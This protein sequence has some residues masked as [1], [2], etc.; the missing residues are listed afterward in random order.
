VQ[1]RTLAISY[2]PVTLAKTGQTVVS[3]SV[4]GSS[5]VKVGVTWHI[6]GT[7]AVSGS[8]GKSV[9]EWTVPAGQFGDLGR[10]STGT[11]ILPASWGAGTDVAVVKEGAY[12]RLY[13]KRFDI[14]GT[15]VVTAVN[16]AAGGWSAPVVVKTTGT[17]TY[18]V[19]AHPEQ[20]TPIL[21]YALNGPGTNTAGTYHLYTIRL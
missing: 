17:W 18:A 19:H 1:G 15:D 6:F 16:K 5:A 3:G 11:T 9:V 20:A 8:Y 4:G 14:V 21:T 7:R 2:D 12:L 13:T 10:W